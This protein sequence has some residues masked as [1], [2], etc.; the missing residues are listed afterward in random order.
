[1]CMDYG[2]QCIVCV[3]LLGTP[4]GSKFMQALSHVMRKDGR[5]LEVMKLL[6]TTAHIMSFTPGTRDHDKFQRRPCVTSQLTKE[7]YFS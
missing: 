4:H 2:M 6:A 7:F 1:M 5:R 3:T